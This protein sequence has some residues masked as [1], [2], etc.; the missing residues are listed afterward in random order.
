MVGS[1]RRLPGASGRAAALLGALLCVAC[2]P[3]P[4]SEVYVR[5]PAAYERSRRLL[6]DGSLE[7]PYEDL[8]SGL[9][10]V[11]PGGVLHLGAGVY[12]GPVAVDR[13]LRIVAMEKAAP[14]IEAGES[15]FGVRVRDAKASLQGVAVRAPERKSEA[16]EEKRSTEGVS[17]LG[18]SDVTIQN[19]V[20]T[21]FRTGVRAEPA[22]GAAVIVQDSEIRGS[23]DYGVDA[24]GSGE[25]VLTGTLIS[26]SGVTGVRIEDGI[27]FKMLR[28]RVSG[29]GNF[30]VE[31]G[32]RA[33]GE[34][35]G[36]YVERSGLSGVAFRTPGRLTIKGNESMENGAYGFAC[37]ARG[38]FDCSGN[39]AERNGRAAMDEPCTEACAP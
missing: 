19:A 3:A 34:M 10:H 37:L 13:D 36:N 32:P 11:L 9:R 30:G 1:T 8:Q 38:D 35:V 29:S 28:C 31:I 39:R 2:D 25:L 23:G 33:E 21:G 26:A 5:K 14:V 20:V 7:R 27:R 22:E 18:R 24:A 16:G 17:I 4:R 12:E 6:A 15:P